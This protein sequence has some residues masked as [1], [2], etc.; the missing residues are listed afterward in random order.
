MDPIIFK[1]CTVPLYRKNGD[2][3]R[4]KNKRVRHVNG[5]SREIQW[6]SILPLNLLDVASKKEE[7]LSEDS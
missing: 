3:E 1:I 4:T 6:Q 7:F 2:N 5:A